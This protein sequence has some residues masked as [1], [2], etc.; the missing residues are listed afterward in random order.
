MA[1]N[2]PGVKMMANEKAVD[3]SKVTNCKYCQQA[4]VWLKS[5]RTGKPYPVEWDGE[6]RS[7]LGNP[8]VTVNAF[9]NCPYRKQKHD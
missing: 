8:I 6:T 1:R 2:A 3:M 9:H 7:N 4:M 5:E